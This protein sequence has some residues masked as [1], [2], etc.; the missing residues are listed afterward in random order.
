MTS[1]KKKILMVCEAFGGGAAQIFGC[2]G[3]IA[4]QYAHG[5]LHGHALNCVNHNGFS[6]LGGLFGG[7]VKGLFKVVDLLGHAQL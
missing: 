7:S 5:I 2:G 3:A 1:P 6:L 4:L